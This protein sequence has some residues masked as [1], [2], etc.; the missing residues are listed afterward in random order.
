[1]KLAIGSIL[2]LVV[3]AVLSGDVLGQSKQQPLSLTV[4]GQSGKAEVINQNGRFFVDILA[5]ASIGKGSVSFSGPA[6][7]LKLPALAS[8]TTTA[9]TAE[10][11]AASRL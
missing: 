8:D 6:I 4:N 3:T 10:P 5:L 1:M 11:V 2:L 7:V 9:G